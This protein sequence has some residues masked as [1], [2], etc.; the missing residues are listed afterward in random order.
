MKIII[1][2]CIL[3]VSIYSFKIFLAQL[4]APRTHLRGRHARLHLRHGRARVQHVQSWHHPGLAEGDEGN[5][6]V[7]NPL[8]L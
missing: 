6:P 1:L 5:L 7:P 8:A 3:L 4:V 2:Y